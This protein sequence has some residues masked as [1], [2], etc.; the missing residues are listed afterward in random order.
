V[1]RDLVTSGRNQAIVLSGESGAG[2]TENTKQ[3]MN[4]LARL[5]M[6]EGPRRISL[7]SSQEVCDILEGLQSSPLEDQVLA[8]NPILEAFGNAR[9]PKND[10]TSRFGKFVKI[11]FHDSKIAG[12]S[13]QNYLLEKS[14]LCTQQEGD[15]NFHAF[16]QMLLGAPTET[17]NDLLMDSTESRP[18]LI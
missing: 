8:C 15:R 17:L 6:P 4:I 5:S 11:Y 9:T 14:R 2:K 10:N 3:A 12:A 7:H 18:S 16:Y 13:V 1:L